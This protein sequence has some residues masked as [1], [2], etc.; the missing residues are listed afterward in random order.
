MVTIYFDK[1]IFSHLFNARDEKFS[2]LRKKILAHKKDFIFLYSNAHIFDLQRDD[3]NIKYKEMEF[4]QSIVDGCHIRYES[5]NILVTEESPRSV[6]DNAVKLDDVSWLD[7]LDVSK[8]SEEQRRFINNLMD[9]LV[10]ELSGKL[11]VDWLIKREPLDT[12]DLVVTED[13]VIPFLKSYMSNFW[14]SQFYKQIRANTISRYNPTGI[15][16][17]GGTSFDKE[18][19]LSSPLKLSFIDTVN[20]ALKQMCLDASNAGM[21]YSISYMLLDMLGVS[22]EP[23]GKVKIHNL[24]VDSAHSFFGSYCDCLVSE[25]SGMRAK[26]KELYKLFNRNTQVYSIDEFIEKFDEAISNNQKSARE[27]FD[28][29]QN[30]YVA[31][32]II[33]TETSSVGILTHLKTCYQYFGYFSYMIERESKDEKVTMLYKS[34]DANQP[35]LMREIEIVVNRLVNVFNDMGADFSPFDPQKEWPQIQDGK[36]NR[37]LELNDAYMC[38]TK[39]ETFPVLCFWIKL[40]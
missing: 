4:M 17:D 29:I 38:L 26:S 7:E 19:L 13:A 35:L 1:Q 16:A 12:R 3:T 14:D 18:L 8:L 37:M 36:W 23:Q 11:S 33:K 2:I 10:K 6:F 24:Q 27:Y 32:N 39:H 25:D 40:K 22:K 31:R 34:N 20:A 30:D 28:E 9:V 5:P 15:T 21:V